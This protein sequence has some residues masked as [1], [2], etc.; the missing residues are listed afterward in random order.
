LSAELTK[1]H[2][3][4]LFLANLPTGIFHNVFKERHVDSKVTSLHHRVMDSAH[5]LPVQRFE[6]ETSDHIRPLLHLFN[7]I[8]CLVSSMWDAVIYLITF[9]S[10]GNSLFTFY[11]G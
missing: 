4:R 1:T 2:S 11:R 7:V 3:F 10:L 6:S 9:I 8:F 5:N